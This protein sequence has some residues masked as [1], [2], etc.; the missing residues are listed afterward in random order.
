MLCS[1]SLSAC[2]DAPADQEQPAAVIG[3]E[4]AGVRTV[5]LTVRT[6]SVD[7]D[8]NVRVLLPIGFAAAPTRPRP[9]LLLLHGCCNDY[10]SWTRDTSIV[11]ELVGDADVIVA[12]PEGGRVGFYSDWLDGPKWENFHT[13]ELPALLSQRYHATDTWAV[14]GLSMGGF[15]ALSYAA[16]HRDQFVAVAAF[17][18]VTD[19]MRHPGDYQSWLRG[20]GVEPADLWGD[21]E[22]NEKVWRG[23]N[24]TD[25]VP[26]LA[27]LPIYVSIG[28]GRPGPLDDNQLAWDQNETT[29]RSQADNFR[30]AL[31]RADVSATLDYYYRGT[32]TWPYWERSL[33]K[34]WPLLRNALLTAD[35]SR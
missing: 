23:H 11:P 30:A 29:L 7:F 3:V 32:H 12:M 34:A 10:R 17:S 8:A 2:A 31:N 15:G 9:V 19:T 6:P 4:P 27:G 28:T 35:R 33:R 1:G 21:P 5:D 14:A 18:P 13:R 20:E 22:D 24:P 26:R 25:L 16:R